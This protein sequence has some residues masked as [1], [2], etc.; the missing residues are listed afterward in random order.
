LHRHDN[1]TTYREDIVTI[2]S[3]RNIVSVSFWCYCY[4]D[5]FS[6]KSIFLQYRFCIVTIM[7]RHIVM[8]SW[9]YLHKG[10]SCRYHFD[11]A[12]MTIIFQKK[13]IFLQY[14]FCIVMIMP[15]HIVMISWR[16]L[17]KRNVVSA[18]FR[19]CCYDDDFSKK[20]I[21]FTI[22]PRVIDPISALHLMKYIKIILAIAFFFAEL[23]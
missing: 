14:R 11:V 5:N 18:S 1:A 16:Y 9:R 12:A 13:S 22:L 21:V 4:D 20:L 10:M 3:Q 8:I 2:F 19:C 15:R 7:P 17:H 23:P 6:K